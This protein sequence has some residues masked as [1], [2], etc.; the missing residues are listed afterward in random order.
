[1]SILS[2]E[3]KKL[4]VV[5]ARTT[6]AVHTELCRRAGEKGMSLSQYVL[7]VLLSSLEPHV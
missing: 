5:S 2:Y 3:K 1:M 7:S 4:C 6:M